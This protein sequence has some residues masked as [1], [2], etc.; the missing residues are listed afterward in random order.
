MAFAP[1]N[2]DEIGTFTAT[3]KFCNVNYDSEVFNALERSKI[4]KLSDGRI[5]ILGTD[6]QTRFTLAPK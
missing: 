1:I 6:G 2:G 5:Q 4:K 3:K